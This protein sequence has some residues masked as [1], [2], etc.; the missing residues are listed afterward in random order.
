MALRRA[1][2]L[3]LLALAGVAVA[4]VY[5]L[6][7]KV[8]ETPSL[9]TGRSG[10]PVVAVLPFA[11]SSTEGDSAFFADGVHDDLLTKLAKLAAIRVISRTSVLEY[12]DTE[13]KIPEIGAELGADVVLEGFVRV[14]GERI[15]INAQLIDARSDEHLWAETYDRSLTAANVFDVQE[16]I[17]RSITS[18]MNATLTKQDDEQLATIPTDNMAAYRAYRQAMTD[19][20]HQRSV[21]RIELLEAAVALDPSFVRA[22]AELVGVYSLQRASVDG[23]SYIKRAEEALGKVAEL[24]P[25]SAEY[26]VAQAYYVYYVLEDYDQA[27]D[28]LAKAIDRNPSDVHLMELRSWIQRRQ[29]DFAGR[30]ETLRS[31]LV[32]DPRNSSYRY[33]LVIHLVAVHQYDDALAEATIGA[34]KAPEIAALAEW[35]RVKDHRD[36]RR[37]LDATKKIAEGQ[38]QATPWSLWFPLVANREFAGAMELLDEIERPE[39]RT[40]RRADPLGINVARDLYTGR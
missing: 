17:A 1:D 9:S 8:V 7:G 29:G 30:E 15:R 21:D 11:A 18:A 14:A 2:Y 6:V 37:W 40:Q 38:G 16:E 13:L 20:G 10:L 24:A 25:G 5:N 27:Y 3:I 28:L 33:M 36:P 39:R 31:L 12:R 22:W 35:I 23:E 34:D 19:R 26:H 32:L 4:I